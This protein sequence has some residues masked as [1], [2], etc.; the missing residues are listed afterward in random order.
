MWLGNWN[1]YLK[2]ADQILSPDELKHHELSFEFQWGNLYVVVPLTKFDLCE[3]EINNIFSNILGVY[4]L[5]NFIVNIT[6]ISEIGNT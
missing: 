1:F 3:I 5:H 2:Q 6:C 4:I